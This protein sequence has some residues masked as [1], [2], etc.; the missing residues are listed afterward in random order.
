M[1]IVRTVKAGRRIV[2]I[3]QEKKT[4]DIQVPYVL[5]IGMVAN[6]PIKDVDCIINV[7]VIEILNFAGFRLMF[8]KNEVLDFAMDGRLLHNHK[9]SLVKTKTV[10]I[11]PI[12]QDETNNV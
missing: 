4:G 2:G 8:S 9:V 3:V 6:I 11:H 7:Q 1:P 10:L 5:L 12:V